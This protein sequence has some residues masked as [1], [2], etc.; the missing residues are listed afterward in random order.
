MKEQ[1]IAAKKVYGIDTGLLSS[2]GFSFSENTGKLME[3]LVFLQ[4]RRKYKDIYYYKTKGNH[5]VDFYIPS[6]RLAIQVSQDLSNFDTKDR[7]LRS[8]A[9][10]SNELKKK[11]QLQIITLADKEN[12]TVEMKAVEIIPLYEGLLQT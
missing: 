3:N 6:Q 1:Q 10:L 11:H 5:E 12:L 2:V 8:L 4:L 7:E 9:Q